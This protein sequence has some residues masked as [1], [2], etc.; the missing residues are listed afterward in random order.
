MFWLEYKSISNYNFLSSLLL[1]QLTN[2]WVALDVMSA[3][4]AE[5]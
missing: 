1:V 2:S 5:L 3:M 4:L